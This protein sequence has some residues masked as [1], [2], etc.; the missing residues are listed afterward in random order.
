MS[1][2][3]FFSEVKQ[4]N[5]KIDYLVRDHKID[6]SIFSG[7]Y[8]ICKSFGPEII[9]T[10]DNV[11]SFYALPVAKL[12]RIKMVNG[13][14]RHG[15]RLKKLSHYLRM[16]SLHLSQYVLANSKAGLA[17]N[18]IR[19]GFVLYNGIAPKFTNEFSI[20]EKLTKRGKLLGNTEKKQIIVSVANFVPYK[21]YFTVFEALKNLKKEGF[22]FY[23]LIIGDGPLKDKIQQKV[24]DL[25]LADRI[26]LLGIVENVEDYLAVSD[27]FLHSSKGEGCSNA[28]LEAMFSGLPII[29]TRVGGT[30]EITTEDNS[31]LFEYKNSE[32]LGLILKSLLPDRE[33]Q[34]KMG[35]C[36][37]EIAQN[38]FTI[39]RMLANYKE[40][41]NQ[42]IY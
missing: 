20:Q 39:T 25:E 8:R 22:K 17:A 28:I 2:K 4:F 42:I 26:K 14:I 13:S 5:I 40:I 6:L 15:I 21:D 16:I 35:K 29:A 18:K 36:S 27:I 41:I 23:Y 19:N 30:E 31:V 24:N 34:Q 3:I 32:E 1:K 12:L 38:R 33:L 9:H 11:T 7:L 10:W 37:K